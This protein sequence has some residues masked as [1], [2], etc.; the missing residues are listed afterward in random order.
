M[1][2]SHLKTVVQLFRDMVPAITSGMFLITL[3]SCAVFGLQTYLDSSQGSLSVGASVFVK[4]HVHTLFAYPFYHRSLTQ[5]LL[6]ICTMVFL[7]GSLEKGFGT[8]RFLFVCILM[9]TVTGLLYAFLDLL[10]ESNG[11]G[12]TE[13]LVPMA[14]ACVA[15][16][17]THTKMTKAFLCGVSFPTMALPWV[18]VLLT[19]VFIPHTVL[20][21][22]IIS[23]FIGWM[24][25]RGWFSFVDISEAKAGLA[26][27]TPP[28][29]FLR[30]ISMV[31]F[32]PASTEDRRKTLL[33]QI[34][35]TPGS[36]PVQAYAPASSTNIAVSGSAKIY[37]GWSTNVTAA[38]GPTPFSNP[39]ASEAGVGGTSHGHSC[40]HG[41][42]TH[43]HGHP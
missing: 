41:H 8:V 25:G 21:C 13:G 31:A 16:T 12:P 11:K 34:N 24:H 36:Y 9:S 28:F 42:H 30:S 18:F 7:S 4:G 23:T 27:K 2:T 5:L 15:L 19:S 14:L 38:S 35:P 32:V 29:R 6:S 33:P 26:E 40:A 3:T 37:E 20:P 17:T 22:S 39:H 43:S 10:Q 1:N